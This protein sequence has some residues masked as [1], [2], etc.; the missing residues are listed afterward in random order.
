V[1]Q[2][3]PDN[4]PCFCS[5]C[6]LVMFPFGPLDNI[7]LL[8]LYKC[9]FPSWIDSEPSFKTTS[10]LT[11]LPNFEEYDIK[12]NLPCNV[13]SSYHTPQDLFKVPTTADDLSLFLLNIRS[14]SLHPD[15]RV[16]TLA[17]LKTSIGVIALSE[18]LTSVGNPIKTNVDNP[19]YSYFL[20]QSRS[21]NGGVSLYVKSG[22]TG[23][24]IPDIGIESIDFES[25]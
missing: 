13:N 25:V 22:L 7:E 14:H 6:T 12:E 8:N 18:T 17:T 21:Q 2:T 5:V 4:V 15:E 10:G 20:S 19:G 1:L 24:P 16:S 9:D 3:E 23:I 11:N